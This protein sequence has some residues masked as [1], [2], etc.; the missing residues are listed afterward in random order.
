MRIVAGI[1]LLLIIALV[2]SRWSFTRVRLPLMRVPLYLTGTEYI[3]VGVVLGPHLLGLLDAAA[4]RG[5]QPLLSLALGWIGLLFGV[6]LERARIRLFPRQHLAVAVIQGLVTLGCCFVGLLWLVPRCG[7]GGGAVEVVALALA[8]VA[9]PTAQSSLALIQRQRVGR[10]PPVLELLRYVAGVDGVVGLVAMG[11]LFC[12]GHTRSIIGLERMFFWQCLLLSLVLGGA[13]GVLLHL[14]TRLRCTQQ[15]LLLFIIGVVVFAGGAAD[16][17]GLSP[18]FVTLLGGLLVANVRGE[19]TRIMRALA[20]L[21]RPIYLVVVLVAGAQ[22]V[23]VEPLSGAAALA[24]GYLVLRVAGKAIGGW[25]AVRLWP[26]PVRLP[27]RI[28]LGLLSQGGLAA[29]MTVEFHRGHVGGAG[30]VVLAVV[31][32]A[33]VVNELVSP[34]LAS[35]GLG[36]EG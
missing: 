27:G 28:G 19:K 13:T 11:C 21:E 33:I 34:A 15:E 17:L 18:L 4:V 6:Q 29:A 1:V 10:P 14:L 3:L 2:G 23:P 5:L 22:L 31:L 36:R 12:L 16:Y 20:V 25:L 26:G 9:V 7:V 30:D 24:G 32:V 8:A 35:V